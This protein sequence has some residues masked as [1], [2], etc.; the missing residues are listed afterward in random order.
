MAECHKLSLNTVPKSIIVAFKALSVCKTVIRALVPPEP[1][2]GYNEL[3]VKL[4]I[5]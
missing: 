3:D 2:D 1:Y 4:Y 5:S